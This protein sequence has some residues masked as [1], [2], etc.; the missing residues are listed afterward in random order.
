M[1][2]DLLLSYSRA[3]VGLLYCVR[4]NASPRPTEI[5]WAERATAML[6]PESCSSYRAAAERRRAQKW[7]AVE[8]S[9]PGPCVERQAA[10]GRQSLVVKPQ[11]GSSAPPCA[12]AE[13]R[14]D[15]Q[16]CAER[17]ALHW[18]PEAEG[19]KG[20]MEAEANHPACPLLWRMV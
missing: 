13:G 11:L 16:P 20:G 2:F 17:G 10:V 18:A 15:V 7:R 19:G 4:L 5:P 8:M 1:F 9:E 6:V 14:G 12:E 3:T